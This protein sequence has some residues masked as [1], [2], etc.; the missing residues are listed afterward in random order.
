VM[1][2]ARRVPRRTPSYV[3][4][5]GLP[6]HNMGP[7]VGYFEGGLEPADAN[8]TP[9]DWP[10]QMPN[11]AMVGCPGAAARRRARI[12]RPGS[13]S[14]SA[15]PEDLWLLARASGGAGPRIGKK[16]ATTPRRS[17]RRRR[18]P[19]PAA[20]ALYACQH[21]G[22]STLPARDPSRQR[23]R[24]RQIRGGGHAAPPPAS[25]RARDP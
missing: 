24:T 20:P 1:P 19:L 9:D 12:R 15:A 8:R 16:K 4:I 25:R 2:M 6:H 11:G 22:Q 18:A 14:D 17:S 10:S 3:S 21:G 7:G 5:R 23:S 13:R